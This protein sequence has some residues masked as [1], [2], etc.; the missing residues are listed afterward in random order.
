[1]LPQ[2]LKIIPLTVLMYLG[3]FTGM[4][5]ISG[6]IFR[7][8]LAPVYAATG[9]FSRTVIASITLYAVGNYLGGYMMARFSPALVAPAMIAGY[10]LMQVLFTMLVI[11]YRPSLWIIP[12]TLVVMG[13]CVWVSLLLKS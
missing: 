12:A 4:F 3:I 5:F 10:A 6:Q 2:F 13:G 9:F 7:G 8:W 1:M 11:G